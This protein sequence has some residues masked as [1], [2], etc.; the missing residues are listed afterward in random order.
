MLCGLAVIWFLNIT[1]HFTNSI[2]LCLALLIILL[3]HR[4]WYSHFAIFS[5]E[6]T[7]YKDMIIAK[8]RKPTQSQKNEE[9]PVSGVYQI[10]WLIAKRISVSKMKIQKLGTSVFK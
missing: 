4:G 3:K 2:L 5:N 1:F 6:N 8:R 9:I 10:M 7:Y